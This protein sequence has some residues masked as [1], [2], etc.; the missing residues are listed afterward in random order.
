[1]SRLKH[2]SPVPIEQLQQSFVPAEETLIEA[3]NDPL[4]T[5]DDASQ[6]K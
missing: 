2:Q 3:T 5:N 1:L 6:K 4:A